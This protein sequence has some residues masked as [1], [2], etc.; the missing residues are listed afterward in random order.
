MTRA[1]NLQAD[2]EPAFGKAARHAGRRLSGEV[3]GIA[4]RRP[5]GPARQPRAR[6]HLEPRFE[7][8]YG[9]CRGE[10]EIVIL[11][12][13]RNTLVVLMSAFGGKSDIDH[14]TA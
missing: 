3:E 5:F 12:K 1:D 4:E 2:R 10:Q 13:R 7:G 8:G 11:V 9:Q 6:R 14:Q